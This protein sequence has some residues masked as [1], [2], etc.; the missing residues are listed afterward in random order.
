MQIQISMC[1][2][3]H[4]ILPHIDQKHLDLHGLPSQSGERS[5]ADAPQ[6]VHDSRSLEETGNPQSLIL[7]PGTDR[8]LVRGGFDVLEAGCFH[9]LGELE[10]A[11][12]VGAYH[13]HAGFD[14]VDVVAEGVG[15]VGGDGA[16]VGLGAVVY[17][18]EFEVAAWF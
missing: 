1:I 7:R 11:L 12:G 10:D 13:A 8:A 17:V 6:S 2:Q 5:L 16:V 18:L 3:I 14:V 9:F 15:L 4:E